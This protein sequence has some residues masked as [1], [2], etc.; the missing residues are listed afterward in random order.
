MSSSTINRSKLRDLISRLQY[1][2]GGLEE[3]IGALVFQQPPH[4]S[5]R[6]WL[7]LGLDGSREGRDD[8]E[9]L[10]EHLCSAVEA[11]G[12][13]SRRQLPPLLLQE[14]AGPALDRRSSRGEP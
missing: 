7:G 2:V 13:P 5:L 14:E 1:L 3:S 10:A 4:A 11:A 6:H 8:L 12:D 9:G